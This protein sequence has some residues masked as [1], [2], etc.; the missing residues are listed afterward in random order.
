MSYQVWTKD[1]YTGWTRKDCD[2][3]VVA[4]DEVLAALKKGLEPLLT[5]EV[6]FNVSI[7]IKEAKVSE[8]I[9]VEARRDKDPGTEG[10]SKVRPGDTPAVPELNP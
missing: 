1:E 9:K 6:P 10:K 8:V 7:E 5:V 3:L 4:R 2:D